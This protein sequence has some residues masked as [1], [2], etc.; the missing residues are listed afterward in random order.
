[1]KFPDKLYIN[2]YMI[3]P[4]MMRPA[5][6]PPDTPDIEYVLKDALVEWLIEQRDYWASLDEQLV[7]GAIDK[8]EVYQE[9]I[10][11]LNTI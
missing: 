11:K 1:M 3:R 7:S 10:D 5:E 2:K 9:V 6:Y 4:G 8:Y